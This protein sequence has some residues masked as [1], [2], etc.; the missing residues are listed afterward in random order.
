MEMD[1][2]LGLLGSASFTY[3]REIFPTQFLISHQLTPNLRYLLAWTM[4]Q[5]SGKKELDSLQYWINISQNWRRRSGANQPRLSHETRQLNSDGHLTLNKGHASRA[6][7]CRV[8]IDIISN[9]YDTLLP[10]QRT[11]GAP[12]CPRLCTELPISNSC[13]EVRCWRL[14]KAPCPPVTPTDG[15]ITA[16]GP[17]SGQAFLP[18]P[19]LATALRSGVHPQQS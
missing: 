1:E 10:G 12:F 7:G 18:L 17:G 6:L 3:R 16:N 2:E 13:R 8:S 19:G 9:L 4:D 5:D 11:P 15:R 14:Q